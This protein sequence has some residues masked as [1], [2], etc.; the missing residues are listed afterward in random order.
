[1]HSVATVP[2]SVHDRLVV[3]CLGTVALAAVLIVTACGGDDGSTSDAEPLPDPKDLVLQPSDLPR[4]F[5]VV[6]GERIPVPLGSVV[7]DPR[8]DRSRT[9]MRRERVS[10]YQTSFRSP[11]LGRIECAVAV[12]RSRSGAK[13]VFRLRNEGF[14]AF[15]TSSASGQPT[16]VETIGEEAGAY[17]FEIRG[18][19]RV[20]VVWR[21][22]NVPASWTTVRHEAPELGQLVSVAQA[23]QVGSR[24]RWARPRR[25]HVCPAGVAVPAQSVTI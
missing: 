20:T 18:S 16:R 21:Y 19:K 12:Y 10:G 5:S 8:S 17:R 3:R 25:S 7:A 11:E 1:M 4:R 13:E 24:G 22:R 14:G 9:V 15:L 6:P 2:V 23:Q